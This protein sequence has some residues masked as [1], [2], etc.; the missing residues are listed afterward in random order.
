MTRADPIERVL[1]VLSLLHESTAPMT[2]EDIVAKLAMGATPYPED[3]EAQ[4]QAFTADRRSIAAGIG[5][6]IRQRVRPGDKH[7]RTEYWIDRSDLLLPDLG[8]DDEERLVLAVALGAVSRRLPGA[9]EA[10]LK[11]GP[12]VASEPALEF[13]LEVSDDVV[14]LMDAARDGG[15][16][17]LTVVGGRFE[18]EPWV[19]SHESGTWIVIGHDIAVGAARAVR[20]D[21][22][23]EPIKR[24]ERRRSVPRP[25]I[26]ADFLASVAGARRADAASA[27]VLVDELTAARAA[28]SSTVRERREPDLFGRVELT[29]EIGDPARFRSWLLGL[30]ARAEVLAPAETRDEIVAWL[31]AIAEAPTSGAAVPPRPATPTKRP[32]PES[33]EARLRRLVSIVPWLYRQGTARI[34]DIAARVGV[35]PE[36]VLRDLTTASMCGVPPY[37]SDVLYGFWVDPEAGEVNVVAPTLLTRDVRL[38]AR[39][40]VA[41]GVALATIEALPGSHREVAARLRKKL[42]VATGE[43]PMAVSVDDQPLLGDLRAAVERHERVCV[44]Y[45]GP[46]DQLTV[47]DLDPHKLFVDRG[48]TYLI[49]DDHLRGDQRIFRTDRVL[50]VR[51]LGT[52]FEPRPVTIPAGRSWTWMVPADDV[53]VH[54]PPGSDWVLDRYA[55]VANIVGEDGWST[56]WLSVVSERW[57]ASLLLRCGPGAEVLEPARYADL[58]AL[59]AREALTRYR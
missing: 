34:D 8:L 23:T 4:R 15:V 37:T 21:R 51:S 29:V 12:D 54:L 45:V 55:I 47:R 35:T 16:V 30:G 10:L 18:F 11:L 17:E 1:N 38:T 42:N 31:E 53:V 49:A 46:D 56:V 44:E 52:Y 6:A 36:Q 3:P 2:R 25:T 22:M 27:V 28:L 7:G 43:L 48:V 50:S 33:V 59:H 20:L 19:V 57:L 40:A 26:D 32:G 5:I 58:P 9:G 24:L 41:V 13:N 39:Q 14:A